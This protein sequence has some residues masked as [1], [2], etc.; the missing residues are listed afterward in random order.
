MTRGA[1]NAFRTCI[2]V[3]H[4]HFHWLWARL[5]YS[6]RK[7]SPFLRLSHR[8]AAANSSKSGVG[9]LPSP[10]TRWMRR[11]P[12]LTC[13]CQ[14]GPRISPTASCAC[15]GSSRAPAAQ[16]PAA[17]CTNKNLRHVRT[18]QAGW[19]IQRK[20]GARWHTVGTQLARSW[21]APT[22]DLARAN[23]SAG[24][25]QVLSWRAPSPELARAKS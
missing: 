16:R 13:T 6:L 7:L 8:M 2:R 5:Y 15:R 12:G 19:I 3:P 4:G 11:R 14:C 24:A 1:D 23:S 21:R 10:Q 22:Q 9:G 18:W 17:W 25:R 20:V